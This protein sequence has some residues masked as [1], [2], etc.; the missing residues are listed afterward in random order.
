MKYLLSGAYHLNKR[1]FVNIFWDVYRKQLLVVVNTEWKK[2]ALIVTSEAIL[3]KEFF[4]QLYSRCIR[5][6]CKQ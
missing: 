4:R 6:A 3:S 5:I 1:N 2:E